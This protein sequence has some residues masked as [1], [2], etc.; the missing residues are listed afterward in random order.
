[1]LAVLCDEV[2]FTSDLIPVRVVDPEEYVG[3]DA[4]GHP[5]KLQVLLYLLL[6]ALCILNY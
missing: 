3:D 1:M 6:V 5:R 4:K 2:D